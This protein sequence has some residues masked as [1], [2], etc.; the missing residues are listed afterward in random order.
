M[1]TRS[2]KA[3]EDKE[4]HFIHKHGQTII[5]ESYTSV[6]HTIRFNAV[7][8]PLGLPSTFQQLGIQ[9]VAGNHSSPQDPGF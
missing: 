1:F 6:V 3:C 7:D 9:L 2:N 4:K 8:T 5:L